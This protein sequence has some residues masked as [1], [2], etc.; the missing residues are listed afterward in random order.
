MARTFTSTILALRTHVL[1]QRRVAP[2]LLIL[3]TLMLA[4][5]LCS[6]ATDEKIATQ[7]KLLADSGFRPKPGGFGFENW[8]GDQYPTSALTPEDARDL[9]GDRVCARFSAGSCVP[10]PAAKLWLQEM[11]QMMKGGHCEG[12]AALSAAFH[13]RKESAADFGAPQTYDLRPQKAELLRTISTYFATQALEPVNKATSATREWPLQKIVDQVI[14]TLGSKTDYITLGIYGAD[15]G[16]AVTPFMVE[17][18]ATGTYRVH[19]YDNNYP[20]VAKHVDIDVSNDRWTYAGAAL[21]PKEDPA[22]WQGG[23][24]TMD[25]TLLSTRYEPLLCP[26]CGGHQ[27]PKAP[28]QP[29]DSNV[30]RKPSSGSTDGY[31]VVTPARCSQVQA[32]RKSDKKQLSG[33][34]QGAKK[35]I[36]GASMV[37]LRGSRGCV[38]RLPRD[39]Q[40]DVAL[41]NDGMSSGSSTSGIT[42][43]YPGSVYSVSGIVFTQNENQT[44]SI[45][46]DNFSYIAGGEQKPTLRVAGDK[47]GANTLY[48]VTGF[49]LH[50]GKSLTASE[51]AEGRIILHDD[52]AALDMCDISAEVVDESESES[53]DL[54][55]INLGD[56]GQVILHAEDGDLDVSIDSDS[57]GSPDNVDTDD[58]NDGTP[59]SKDTDDD[60]DGIA[61]DKE[62]ADSDGDS[63]PDAKDTD[64]DNDGEPDSNDPDGLSNVAAHSDSDHDG[65]ADEADTDDDND[66]VTDTADSDDDND[67]TPD[68]QEDDRDEGADDTD[69]S[70]NQAEAD[71][72][73]TEASDEQGSI[74]DSD[75]ASADAHDSHAGDDVDSDREDE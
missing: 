41:V 16:H 13:V 39:Q 44:F 28:N 65:V 26:F 59:D 37:P 30:V 34:K 71:E 52:D 75:G 67:G 31:T 58:D 45:N 66:G 25:V 21:N 72:H 32:T 53:Y 46:K 11:N 35:E 68:S 23:Q 4:A 22:P 70:S 47:D 17:S 56:N 18:L 38:V 1:L 10:T 7:G 43:F 40:Y 6:H 29:Q 24:G 60:N 49:T 55:N 64:D 3:A 61:D 48:E 50:D 20:G 73:D 69:N 54:D 57:D 8:G 51:D 62:L 74:D 14:T 27:P 15:G 19:V 33:A 36:S 9:F 5:P 42:I 63:I 12:M 2:S